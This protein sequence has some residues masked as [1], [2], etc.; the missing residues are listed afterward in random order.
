V[1]DWGFCVPFEQYQR[2]PDG[3]YEIDLMTE[4]LPAEMLVGECRIQ[5]ESPDTIVFNAHTCHA[6][7]FND[8]FAGVALIFELFNWLRDRRPHYSYLAVFG[9]EHLGTAFYLSSLREEE[10]KRLK[11]ACFIEMIGIEYP[12][13]LQHSFLG[14]SILDQV[15][16][17]VLNDTV[18]KSGEGSLKTGEFRTIVGNDETVW[19]GA[20]IE[21]PCISISRCYHDF[22]YKEYHT[23]RDDLERNSLE[24]LWQAFMA[25][26]RIVRILEEDRLIARKF[27]GLIALSNPK[28]GLYIERPDPVLDKRLSDEQLRMGRLQDRLPR[29]LD[30]QH[31]VFQIA[32][33]FGVP[34][35][36]LKSYL[37]RFVEKGL[38][39]I[40]HVPGL[41]WY[42]LSKE[43][44]SHPRAPH[45][46]C[47]SLNS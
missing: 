3:E 23:H 22:Y 16:R 37:E 7:Q 44:G 13:V 38:A 21:I 24:K 30:G 46:E 36:V 31:S 6:A 33:R 34:F 10:L 19:E 9:P 20:G 26:Q 28:Y 41:D 27:K 43:A 17:Y 45:G 47:P 2:W 4:Y 32:D 12:L 15:A 25:I 29:F 14:D 1:R 18:Q 42:S 8:G 11:L 5:G 40:L 39:D 35:E